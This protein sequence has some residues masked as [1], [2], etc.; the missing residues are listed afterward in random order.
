MIVI[1][2]SGTKEDDALTTVSKARLAPRPVKRVRNS[3]LPQGPE[4]VEDAVDSQ[5][6][7]IQNIPNPDRPYNTR[8]P[9]RRPAKHLGLNWQQQER[10]EQEATIVKA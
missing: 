6:Q 3:S 5:D 10:E 7:P 2:D 8:Y 9:G 1:T 4:V